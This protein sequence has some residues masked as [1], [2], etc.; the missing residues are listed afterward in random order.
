[1]PENQW[2]KENRN[3]ASACLGY[4]V[5]FA[6]YRVYGLCDLAW[7]H[8]SRSVWFLGGVWAACFS[9][10]AHRIFCFLF[11]NRWLQQSALLNAPVPAAIFSGSPSSPA[12]FAFPHCS[13]FST[14]QNNAKTCRAQPFQAVFTNPSPSILADFRDKLPLIAP[15][16]ANPTPAPAAL[17]HIM[18]RPP[19]NKAIEPAKIAVAP[20]RHID[21]DNFIRV[22]NS[23][24]RVDSHLTFVL[25][26]TVG[27]VCL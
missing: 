26:H 10:L 1:M 16:A 8:S 23:V 2:R 18:P 22:R 24:S 19:K 15:K 14:C 5:P 13:P 4:Y 3:E 21:V 17:K 11:L 25:H 9:S 7:C 12:S 27:T 6:Q 20:P